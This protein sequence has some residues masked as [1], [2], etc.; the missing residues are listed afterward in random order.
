[1]NLSSCSPPPHKKDLLNKYISLFLEGRWVGV[2]ATYIS[3]SQFWVWLL[4]YCSVGIGTLAAAFCYESSA[5]CFSDPERLLSPANTTLTVVRPVCL[6]VNVV[7]L[8]DLG[9]NQ[10]NICD[11]EVAVAYNKLYLG[12][13]ST[14]LHGCGGRGDG[15]QGDLPEVI[16]LGPLSRK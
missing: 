16:A 8:R 1:M 6:H 12:G 9:A 14:G 4:S 11:H 7:S 15:S 5:V 2:P 13:V 10:G 3:K